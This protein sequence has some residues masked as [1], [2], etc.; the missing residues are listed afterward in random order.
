MKSKSPQ[1]AEVVVGLPVEGPFDYSINQEIDKNIAVGTRVRVSFNH[2]NRLGVITGLKEKSEFKKLNPII[3]VLDN[4]PTLDALAMLLA[5]QLRDYY[6]CSL[7]EAIEAYLPAM[8][9]KEKSVSNINRNVEIRNAPNQGMDKEYVF[10][11]DREVRWSKIND[12]IGK[13][14]DKKTFVIFLVPEQSQLTYVVEKLSSFS[15]SP[16]F[17]LDKTLTAKKELEVWQ[18]IQKNNFGVII[19][20][21]SAVFA[22]ASPL[23]LI[24]VYDEENLSYKQEQVP[25][26]HVHR[27]A[28]MRAEIDS[29][30]VMLVGS[31]PLAQSWYEAKKNGFKPE[32]NL[33]RDVNIQLVD[34]TNYNPRK[35]S[36]ISYPVQNHIAK[37]LQD[38]GKVILFINRRGLASVTRCQ[39]CSHILKCP[40]CQ[41][42]LT[43]LYSKKILMCRLCNHKEE[44]PKTCPG[45][46]GS[47]LKSQ[48]AG[49]EKLVNQLLRIYPHLNIVRF[50]K[51]SKSLAKDFNVVIATQAIMRFKDVVQADFTAV[52]NFDSQLHHLDFRSAQRTFSLLIHLRDMTKKKM[53]VQ[54]SMPDNYCLK[55]LIKNDRELFY[56][57]ELKIR[58]S[59]ALPPYKH[60]LAIGMRGRNEEHVFEQCQKLFQLLGEQEEKSIEITDP[61]PDVMPKLR[62]KY[63]YTIVLKGNSV[64]KM[65][66]LTKE[67]LKGLKKKSDLIVTVNVD[68]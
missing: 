42:S 54:T 25:H 60:L 39:Q 36:I 3:S 47:Y 67:V 15:E 18:A 43:Y 16:L 61:H 14:L 17:V 8:L 51:D 59:L 40:R 12:A 11:E 13:A 31:A 35:T 58:K 56:K 6:G 10:D 28:Q 32:K 20:L 52:L 33:K 4:K 19:G 38:R 64:K 7:G 45:C 34:M 65:L 46:Q 57:E 1:I 30:S 24:V 53:I 62:D 5:K 50:D 41:V 55:A 44:L 37:T 23:G 63:R 68:P 2:R 48:G 66:S 49:I 21:R 26:Y 22:P 29:C 27:V 9:R